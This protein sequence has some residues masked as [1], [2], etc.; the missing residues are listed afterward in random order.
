MPPSGEKTAQPES[1]LA[2]LIAISDR[3]MAGVG[4]IIFAS[5]LWLRRDPLVLL[6]PRPWFDRPL[7][8]V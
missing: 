2:A 4:I 3:H 8:L 7:P 5:L 6:N 1:K